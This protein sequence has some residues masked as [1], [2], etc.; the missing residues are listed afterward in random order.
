MTNICEVTSS[1][2]YRVT[3]SRYALI[4]RMDNMPAILLG[5]FQFA[6]DKKQTD[7]IQ[8]MEHFI[9]SYFTDECR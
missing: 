2:Y 9:T 7:V 3:G 1:L 8:E 5:T 4:D 6:P